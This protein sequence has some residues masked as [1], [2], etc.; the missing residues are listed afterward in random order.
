MGNIGKST[1]DD[2]TWNSEEDPFI[3]L[4]VDERQKVI[5]KMKLNKIE[6]GYYLLPLH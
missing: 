3:N 5:K 6:D 2:T 1:K 4:S